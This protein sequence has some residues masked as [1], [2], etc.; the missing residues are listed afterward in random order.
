T[1]VGGLALFG[2]GYRGITAYSVRV[3]MFSYCT[4]ECPLNGCATNSSCQ[5]SLCV[6]KF[7]PASFLCDDQVCNEVCDGGGRCI[8]GNAPIYTNCDNGVWCDGKDHC[9][10]NGT[11]INLQQTIA[12]C[13]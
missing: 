8:F 4:S 12:P 10:G 11:C 1:T 5:N 6:Y 3:D 9:D 13:E 2:G 7:K